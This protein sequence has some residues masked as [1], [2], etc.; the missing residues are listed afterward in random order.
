MCFNWQITSRTSRRKHITE[1]RSGEQDLESVFW[2][3]SNFPTLDL[4]AF[5][6]TVTP[7]FFLLFAV[8]AGI[9]VLLNSLSTKD[10][11]VS[12]IWSALVLLL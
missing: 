11:V 12:V 4:L 5:N 9:H 7:F 1:E 6:P 3:V 8:K 10:Q 2:L